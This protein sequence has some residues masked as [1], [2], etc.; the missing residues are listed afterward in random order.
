MPLP[1]STVIALGALAATACGPDR[2]TAPGVR[3]GGGAGLT[4]T[5]GESRG[6]SVLAYAKPHLA[7]VVRDGA[8][9]PLAGV[10]LLVEARPASDPSRP[11]QPA[12][13]LCPPSRSCELNA[14]NTID[15]DIATTLTTDD[16][17]R[18]TIRV[19]FGIVPGEAVVVVSAQSLGLRDSVAYLV[20]PGAPAQVIGSVPDT[21]VYVGGR[22]RIVAAAFDR[23]GN[24]RPDRVVQF[25]SAR[26]DIATVAV[27]GVVSAVAVGR[28][29]V[30]ATAGGASA[31]FFV[32]VPP[33]GVLVANE[34]RS[35]AEFGAAAYAGVVSVEL[36]GSNY[37]RLVAT[38]S[39]GQYP[40]DWAPNG[41]D[42]LFHDATADGVRAF[43]LDAA[44][45]VRRVTADP[46]PFKREL[47]GRFAPDGRTVYFTAVQGDAPLL[48]HSLWRANPDGTVANLG[49]APAI[50]S[51][52][53]RA[54][55]SPDGTRLAYVTNRRG[56][57][58]V[59][60]TLDLAT[61]VIDRLDVPGQYPAWAPGGDVLAYSAFDAS[62]GVSG[63]VMVMRP[64]GTGQRVVAPAGEYAEG[65]DWSGDGRWLLVRNR[66][67]NRYEL[68][69]AQGG[70]AI[71]LPYTRY[72]NG[73]TLR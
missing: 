62:G 42:V 68:L 36:D 26:A 16:L 39:A 40:V 11:V 41:Q 35:P 10:S 1:R 70:E 19:R 46:V 31:A 44:G 14:G 64:D 17:G 60:R 23:W 4:L 2:P 63:A 49:P 29:R 50:D 12:A 3:P 9:R 5:P 54:A 8:G 34:T 66:T 43:V 21:A 71:P 45:V 56:Y 69:P 30:E 28:G 55:V 59:M 61:G 33:R 38:R 37:R 58:A 27:D 53:W 67:A 73:A 65:A 22:Y 57:P 52:D 48:S 6:D 72:L 32:S 13:F 7:I 20:A 51:T 18:A 24:A 15:A 25:S 47:H